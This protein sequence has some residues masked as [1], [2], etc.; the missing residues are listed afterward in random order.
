[1]HAHAVQCAK[2]TA[3]T[4][5]MLQAWS[6]FTY[7]ADAMEAMEPALPYVNSC[8]LAQEGAST[9]RASCGHAKMPKWACSLSKHC[10]NVFPSRSAAHAKY[11]AQHSI[12]RAGCGSH[13]GTRGLR[14][15]CG[16]CGARGCS[17]APEGGAAGSRSPAGGSQPAACRERGACQAVWCCL[18]A[19]LT[20]CSAHRVFKDLLERQTANG[21]NGRRHS[22][23]LCFTSHDPMRT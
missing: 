2:P 12:G 3:V 4:V 11:A 6:I 21:S 1:M 18:P 22:T 17:A 15:S 13:G 5:Q 14:C 20:A 16:R 23:T 8:L 10:I 7:A 9:C 19:A